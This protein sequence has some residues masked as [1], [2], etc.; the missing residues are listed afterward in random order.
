MDREVIKK[1]VDSSIR[2]KLINEIKQQCTLYKIEG[3]TSV[4]KRACLKE[5]TSRNMLLIVYLYTCLNDASSHTFIYLQG[6]HS[7]KY[8]TLDFE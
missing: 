7:C 2:L 4:K 3:S 8:K 6:G 1:G 5:K